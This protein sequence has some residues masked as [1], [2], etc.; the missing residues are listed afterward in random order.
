MADGGMPDWVPSVFKRCYRSKK[1][2]WGLSAEFVTYDHDTHGSPEPSRSGNWYVSHVDPG[3]ALVTNLAVARGKTSNE[4]SMGYPEDMKWKEPV[5]FDFD[6]D[7]EDE[8][9]VTGTAHVSESSDYAFGQVWAVGQRGFPPW[10]ISE[11]ELR[12]TFH[13]FYDS[14]DFDGDGRP[15]LVTH[16]HYVA[17]STRP[18]GSSSPHTDYGPPLLAHS[19]ADGTFSS[20]DAVAERYALRSCPRKPAS[21]LDPS[22]DARSIDQELLNV[23]CA[24]IWGASEA[25]VVQRVKRECG[26]P[27]RRCGDVEGM[28]RWAKIEPPVRLKP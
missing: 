7:G 18:T 19:L 27:G 11:Y 24:R 16:G 4:L 5:L 26:P 3:G 2:A 15:D 21:L 13:D 25:D 8:L 17:P 6:G 10:A 14:V 9:I 12:G 22:S 28:L 1:G 20:S 23:I